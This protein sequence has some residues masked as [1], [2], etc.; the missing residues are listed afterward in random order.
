MV[1]E[2]FSISPSLQK[3]LENDDEKEKLTY[4]DIANAYLEISKEI[5]IILDKYHLD[6][7]LDKLKKGYFEL[8]KIIQ[9]IQLKKPKPDNDIAIRLEG[10]DSIWNNKYFLKE[11]MSLYLTTIQKIEQNQQFLKQIKISKWNIIVIVIFS[12]IITFISI[13]GL[14][15]R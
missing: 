13:I 15:D 5:Y 1:Y 10:K 11:S 9:Q 4:F 8:L 14:L 3:I 12:A 2:V 6:I 7:D